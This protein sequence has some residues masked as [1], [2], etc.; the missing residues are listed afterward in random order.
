LNGYADPS[1]N[2]SRKEAPNRT[3]FP[4]QEFQYLQAITMSSTM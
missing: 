3:Y 4:K 1:Y 2:L